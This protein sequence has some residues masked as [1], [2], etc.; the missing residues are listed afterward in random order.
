MEAKMEKTRVFG[1]VGGALIIAAVILIS[2][3]FNAAPT[4]K[5]SSVVSVGMGD[6]QRYEAG[7]AIS[8]GNVY[9]GMGDLHR[10]DTQAALIAPAQQAGPSQSVGMGDLRHLEAIQALTQNIRHMGGR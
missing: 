4:A 3:G 1:L 6:L 8:S 10:L 7:Q 5:G 2:L 9:I